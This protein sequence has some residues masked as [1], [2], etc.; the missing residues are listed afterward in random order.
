MSILRRPVYRNYQAQIR[1]LNRTGTWFP[2]DLLKLGEVGKLDKGSFVRDR[3]LAEL[4]VTVRVEVSD[5]AAVF[6]H[7]SGSQ[8][9]A[10]AGAK[11]ELPIAEG[12]IGFGFAKSGQ[13]VLSARGL[14]HH[15]IENIGEVYD[16]ILQLHGQERWDPSWIV[17]DELWT[18]TYLTAM[19]AEASGAAAVLRAS[20]GALSGLDDLSEVSLGVSLAHR[21]GEVWFNQAANATPFFSGRRVERRGWRRLGLEKISKSVRGPLERGD[22]LDLDSDEDKVELVALDFTD[23]LMA[24]WPESDDD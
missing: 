11:A 5:P 2:T 9:S 7:T 3:T 23:D 6:S 12:E 1:R 4:G 24:S 17:I 10:E 22:A 20:G 18:A 16:A 15:R 8:L 19:I 14:C 21:R 13:Y